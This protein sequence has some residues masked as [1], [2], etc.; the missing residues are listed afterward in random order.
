MDTPVALSIATSDSGCGAGIQADLLTFRSCGVFGTT[1]F[2]CLTAQN[3][4]GVSAI[5]EL[6]TQFIRDQLSQLSSFFDIRAA[7]TGMLFSEENIR[8]VA[9]FLRAHPEL[10]L[11]VDPVMVATSGAKLLKDEA[12]DCMKSELFPRASLI[13]P[14]LDEAAVLLGDRP[15]NSEEMRDTARKLR[16]AF[17]TSILLKGGHLEDTQSGI[18][19]WFIATDGTE[20]EF[21]HSRIERINTHG[22]GCRLSA[23]IT[24][25]LAKGLDLKGA[26]EYGLSHLQEA[27]K[28]PVILNGE[29]F[30]GY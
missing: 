24:A 22:S 5:A 28:Q 19:D 21:E 30:I 6:E 11:V 23:A 8:T 17:Q 1:A 2:C 4:K 7:K 14:N 26:T 12:I 13:T 10:P 27:M 18:I 3:P 20:K 16:D 25:G 9:E 15:Q 29:P